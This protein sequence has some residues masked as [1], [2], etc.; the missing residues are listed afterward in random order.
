MKKLLMSFC[1][2]LPLYALSAS[3]D[4]TVSAG[5]DVTGLSGATPVI[6]VEGAIPGAVQ[7]ANASRPAN[8]GR[9]TV[10][11]WQPD[12]TAGNTAPSFSGSTWAVVFHDSG[13]LVVDPSITA[14]VSLGVSQPTGLGF[15][16]QPVLVNDLPIYQYF[17]DS[18][19]GFG[20]PASMPSPDPTGVANVN[21][22][23]GTWYA[24][25]SSGTAVV[26]EPST[27]L[28][29]AGGLGLFAALRRRGER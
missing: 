12:I 17:R 4:T 19:S 11:Y 6:Q 3:A 28:L 2:V 18:Q 29:F 13:N 22:I 5:V 7:G 24:V 26:P 14:M 25:S 15:D 9:R 20:D 10:Y 21:G 27:G 1:F 23:Y 16:A 8:S